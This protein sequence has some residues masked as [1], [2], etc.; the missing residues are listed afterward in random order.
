MGTYFGHRTHQRLKVIGIV[1]AAYIS[2]VGVLAWLLPEKN[3]TYSGAF[4]RWFITIPLFFMAWI[5]LEWVGTKLLGLAFWQRMPS[6][7]RVILLVVSIIIVI[8]AV[9]VTVQM[10][11]QPNAL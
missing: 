7:A 6:I 11:Q 3:A 4:L 5:V 2:I 10:V 8:L 9:I 1:A